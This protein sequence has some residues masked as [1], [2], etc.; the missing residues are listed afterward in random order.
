MGKWGRTM[1]FT[2]YQVQGDTWITLAPEVDHCFWRRYGVEIHP[3]QTLSSFGQAFRQV[4]GGVPPLWTGEGGEDVQRWER[5]AHTLHR[6]LE[7]RA[8]IWDELRVEES[9][10]ELRQGLQWLALTKRGIF[11]PGVEATGAAL[12]RRCNR[13]GADASR[14]RTGPCARCGGVCAWC[15]RCVILG[16]NRACMPLVL[17]EPLGNHS[18]EKEVELRLPALSMAQQD[19]ATQCLQWLEREEAELLVWAVTG[20]GKTEMLFPAVRQILEQGEGVLWVSPRRE[21]VTG[22]AQR[23]RRAFPGTEVA[24]VHGETGEIWE[25]RPLTVATVQQTLRYYRRFRLAVVDEADAFPLQEDPRWL[26]GVRRSLIDGGQQVYLTATPPSSWKRRVQRGK[27]A[28]VTVPARF[29]GSPLPVPK[30][31]RLGGL[32]RRL[33]RGA[34]IPQLEFFLK[35]VSAEKG[36]AFLFVPRISDANLVMDWIEQRMPGLKKATGLATGR[37]EKRRETIQ[38]FMEG[39]LQI[40]VTTTVMERGVTVPHC[41]VLVVGADHPVFDRATLIQVAGRVGRDP[42]W[43]QGEVWFLST[44]WTEAQRSAI[45]EIR[46]LNRYAEEKGYLS[47]EREAPGL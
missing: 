14:I 46:S 35:E 23:M 42:A 8:L 44:V 43:P 20:S 16:R 12:R 11:L 5:M 26:Q 36:Q 34:S 37:N 2:I 32:Q 24:E 39:E 29:H 17:V 15:D 10:V 47:V 22:V 41:H 31:Y 9:E 3:V 4:T 1:D 27:M 33:E 21:V 25:N 38:S 7:G 18:A 28:S 45:R 30:V 13:C 40:L 6:R 19:A